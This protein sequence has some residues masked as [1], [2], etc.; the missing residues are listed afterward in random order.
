[1]LVFAVAG[2]IVLL[3]QA[4]RPLAASR[5][6]AERIPVLGGRIV[7]ERLDDP[8]TAATLG[9][10]RSHLTMALGAV[11]VMAALS[12]F[13]GWYGVA[14]LAAFGLVLGGAESNHLSMLA[15]GFVLNWIGYR[16]DGP[17]FVVAP[18][19]L[20]QMAGLAIMAS[21]LTLFTASTVGELLPAPP[22]DAAAG[23]VLPA[24]AITAAGATRGGWNARSMIAAR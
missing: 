8:A 12:R 14:L 20:M 23:A 15:Y 9:A 10:L 21:A 2:A 18:A 19:D 16:I 6:T 17:V 24:G 13:M 22:S 7:L 11:V 5:L 1:M 4:L 3:D